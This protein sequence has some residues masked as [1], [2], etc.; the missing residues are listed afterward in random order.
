M[1]LHDKPFEKFA[2]L[3]SVTYDLTLL[4]YDSASDSVKTLACDSTIKSKCQIR[5]S[6]DF[7][8]ILYQ[9][10]PPI[11]FL[12]EEIAFWVDPRKA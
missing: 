8:P 4:S 5:Y 10:S 11:L 1:Y 2:T 3:D 12:D 6:R 7:T 9:I